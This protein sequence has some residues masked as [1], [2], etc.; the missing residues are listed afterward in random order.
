MNTTC[1]P[2]ILF[3][4]SDQHRAMSTG[5]YGR[6]DAQT[7]NIDRLAESSVLFEQAY[8]QYPICTASRQSMLTG[9][10]PGRSGTYQNMM[11]SLNP[12]EWNIQGA[13]SRSGYETALIGK[14]HCNQ[15]G[16][17][18]CLE[19]QH[20]AETA[21]PKEVFDQINPPHFGL[22]Y[23]ENAKTVRAWPY[24]E[25][26]LHSAF[27]TRHGIDFLK[28]QRH[29]NPFFAFLTF[30]HPHPPFW[31]PQRYFDRFD[32]D[33]F[34]LPPR[35][36]GLPNH[37]FWGNDLLTENRIRQYL[38]GYYAALAYADECI[39]QILDCAENADL[40]ENT[41]VIYSSDHGEAGGHHQ[42]YEKHSFY[43]P[44]IRV[45]LLI[46]APGVAPRRITE[47]VELVDLAPTLLDYCQIEQDAPEPLDGDSL[48]PLMEGVS[49]AWKNQARCENYWPKRRERNGTEKPEEYGRMI[50]RGS[51]KLCVGG[52][53][54]TSETLFDLSNDPD[55]F[56]NLWNDPAYRD[57]R[58]QLLQ[59]LHRDWVRIENPDTPFYLRD[60]AQNITR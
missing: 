58:D 7:P 42:K 35:D 4:F 28:R 55:E 18:Y 39:G 15:N 14:A 11:Q 46:R 45:P 54:P 2:N 47:L 30:E 32:P 48:R 37:P 19:H 22:D 33:R 21:W 10:L 41:I 50:R 57:Q 16:F 43:E 52:N 36:P 49:T 53:M 17:L 25:Q 26:Y 1:R 31:I 3:I 20:W 6:T 38:H 8:C 13:L 9:R 40:L 12:W 60:R 51:L 56:H 59:E 29:G 24:D 34:E 23:R 27:V 44:E 5:C